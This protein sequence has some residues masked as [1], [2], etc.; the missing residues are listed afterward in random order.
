MSSSFLIKLR[1]Y[2]FSN[3][4]LILFFALIF[5]LFLTNTVHESYPD[6]F[7]DILGGWYIL[8][9]KFLYSGFFTHH[10]PFG[11]ILAAVV[12]FFSGQ[13]FVR[14]RWVY[15]IVL[16]VYILW[17][18]LFLQ[19]RFSYEKVRFYLFTILLFAI[20]AT[21]FWGHML[22]ADNVAALLLLPVFALLFLRF[23]TI[24]MALQLFFSPLFTVWPPLLLV[25]ACPI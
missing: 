11:Y 5:L 19:K 6:E 12:E 24:S 9:G 15:A 14:F 1:F 2:F 20:G 13:S 23:F 17:T 22:L 10:N 25:T 16:F 18:Y 4:P 7:D 8:H 21:Y 3:F